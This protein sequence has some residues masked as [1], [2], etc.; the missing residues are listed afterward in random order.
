MN[1][2]NENEHG[3]SIDCMCSMQLCMYELVA[4]SAGQHSW[5]GSMCLFYLYIIFHNSFDEPTLHISV[6]RSDLSMRGRML[7]VR[8]SYH[9]P[10]IKAH[11][12]FFLCL[13]F[14]F[15]CPCLFISRYYYDSRRSID[16]LDAH[17][18][19]IGMAARISRTNFGCVA[20]RRRVL[21]AET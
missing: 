4:G 17:Q 18:N 19:E 20:L 2:L 10:M 15:R 8:S 6:R 5:V 3:K 1:R 12:I 21:N 9:Q 14:E 13:V 7:S 11:R 16:L